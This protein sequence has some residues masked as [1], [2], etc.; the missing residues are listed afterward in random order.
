[1]Y[2]QI[3]HLLGDNQH[4]QLQINCLLNITNA[5]ND[6][7]SSDGLFNMHKAF[8]SREMGVRRMAVYIKKQQQWICVSALNLPDKLKDVDISEDLVHY[9]HISTIGERDS[10]LLKYYKYV[11]PV[12]HKETPVA[13]ALIGDMED[14]AEEYN[15]IKFI[16]T[17]TNIVAVAIENKRLFKK[18]I[19]QERYK[20]EIELAREVQ[21]MLIPATLPREEFFEMASIY[22][23]QLN[24]GGDYFDVFELSKGRYAF[25]IAD[26][27]GKGVSAAL[28]M[29]NFQ[30]TLHCTIQRLSKL[31]ELVRYLNKSVLLV[32]QS[33]KIIT[34]FI[35]II[36][37]HNRTLEYVNAGH[38]PPL[39][40]IGD[41]LFELNK[42][43]TLLGAF[44]DLPEIEVGKVVLDQE[45]LI[46]TFTDGLTDLVNSQGKHFDD[47]VLRPMLQ[48]GISLSAQEM[49]SRIL[50]RIDAYSISKEFPDDIALLT[51]KLSMPKKRKLRKKL[52]A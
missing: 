48:N 28:L 3:E 29:A 38:T 23:P 49:N 6:N 21:N 17:I 52:R 44:D 15:N 18:Q 32:T 37:I 5:I 46:V 2:E 16:T 41:Q 25:C 26:I 24:I 19:E 40:V 45:T 36:N 31:D 42:G 13:Y 30:A 1:M 9:Q 33:E 27:S 22:K 10:E 34:F 8:L 50:D 47:E 43:C 4:K 11:I 35:G 51:C 14:L 12:R 39:M 20:R 7:V